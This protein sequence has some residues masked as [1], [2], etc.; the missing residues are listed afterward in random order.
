YLKNYDEMLEVV[1]GKSDWLRNC[2]LVAKQIDFEM[3]LGKFHFPNFETPD[4]L[5]TGE[6]LTKISH[7]GLQKKFKDKE[8]PREYLSRLEYELEWIIKLGF[9]PY[10]LIIED[11]V[12]FAL[13]Q[14]IPKGPGRGSGAASLVSYSLGIT[15]IDPIEFK[16]LFERFINPA[17]KSMPDM[18]L[19]FDPVR[20][21]EVIEYVRNKYNP[22]YVCNIVTFNRMK[23]RAAVRDSARVLDIPLSDADTVSKMIPFGNT[24]T[25]DEGLETNKELL[26]RYNTEP[27]LRKWLDTARAIEGLV[28]N[29]GVH[30][31][32]VVIADKPVVEYAPLMVSEKDG[33]RVCQYHMNNVD[34]IGLIKMDFLGLRTLSYMRECINILKK[35]KN[36]DIDPMEIPLDDEKTYRLLCDANTLGVFQLESFGMRNLMRDIRPD[37]IGDVIALIALY[38]PGPMKQAPHFANRKHNNQT[39]EYAHPDLKPILDETYGVITYQ[40]QITM[41]LVKLAGIDLSDAVTII[42]I[43]SKKREAAAIDK[44]REEFIKGTNIKGIS[45]SIANEIFDSIVEFA[46]YGFNKSHSA[47]YGLL[48]YWTAFLKANYPTEFYCAFLSSEMHDTEKISEIL[49]ELRKEKIKILPPDVN[50]SFDK[51]KVENDGI[52]FGLVAI[53]GVGSQAVNEIVKARKDGEFKDL[54]DFTGRVNLFSVNR[55]SMVN[56]IKSGA[57]DSL[58]GNRAEKVEAVDRLVETGK[59]T[60]EDRIRG[61]SQLFDFSDS[62]LDGGTTILKPMDEFPREMKLR[63][64][65]HLTGFYLTGHPLEPF[66][67]KMQ[68]TI[69]HTIEKLEALEDGTEVI[70]GGLITH[71]ELKISKKLEQ[72]AVMKLEDFTGSVEVMVFPRTLTDEIKEH[73]VQEAVLMMSG[74]VRS[75]IKETQSE[76][77]ETIETRYV[78]VFLDTAQKHT[79][80]STEID[81]PKVSEIEIS[82]V[83]SIKTQTLE[84]DYSPDTKVR[85]PNCGE[86]VFH[87]P[88]ESGKMVE[89]GERLKDIVERNAGDTDLKVYF[90]MEQG[91]F[92]ADLGVRGV[93]FE[94]VK[95][96]MTGEFSNVSVRV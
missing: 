75:D 93:D 68:K 69:T 66:W 39:I 89:I 92:R 44:Y 53:K 87:L 11:F 12:R 30:P 74:K 94:K 91:R 86:I 61:Q 51:F 81:V 16:L 56:L 8:I 37:W 22:D 90:E 20:R 73:L 5:S 50:K 63:M 29:V 38:R 57:M 60:Q 43:I 77:G 34:A 76:D 14:G 10:F 88:M 54:G 32:G 96:V 1:E 80:P 40:E 62:G 25:I 67:G 17:R 85:E 65:K 3:E 13:D 27:G 49:S 15:D 70:I 35:T 83:Q 4:G 6:Y 95:K 64:E 47:A 36:V 9:A 84:L 33:A 52:R 24:I 2:D 82:R 26:E 79:N 21:E 55:G 59:K 31:A 7:E 46:G 18:D 42:K 45:E 78:K 58:P 28:R 48:A 72:Y 41:I 71:L 23:A 19:D